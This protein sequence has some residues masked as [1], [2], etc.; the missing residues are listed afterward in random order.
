[1]LMNIRP[2]KILLRTRSASS[3]ASS[4]A[5]LCKT[6]ICIGR[7]VSTWLK[8]SLNS[9]LIAPC[10]ERAGMEGITEPVPRVDADH[11]FD[12]QMVSRNFVAPPM[13][14][15]LARYSIVSSVMK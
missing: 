5:A 6:V 12:A 14:P 9:P 1:M 4:N 10:R 7:L 11:R 3:L 15:P 8:N 13:R 2:V